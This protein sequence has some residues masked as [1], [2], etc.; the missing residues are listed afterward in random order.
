MGD[1]AAREAEA[2]SRRLATAIAKEQLWAVQQDCQHNYY[3]VGTQWECQTCG[4]R[5]TDDEYFEIDD[6][7][8]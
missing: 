5:I 1:E 2:F 6:I 3:L 8:F 4:K 7:P